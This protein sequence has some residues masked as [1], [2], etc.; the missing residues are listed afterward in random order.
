MEKKWSIAANIVVSVME[1]T[2]SLQIQIFHALLIA[3]R[4][5]SEE[6]ISGL[7]KAS[8]ITL[9]VGAAKIKAAN[10]LNA[11]SLVP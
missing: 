4:Q 3:R 9:L 8:V 11:F 1:T 5:V 10:C 7:F 6:D 2:M